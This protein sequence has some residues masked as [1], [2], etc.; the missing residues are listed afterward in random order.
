MCGVSRR[1]GRSVEAV[2]EEVHVRKSMIIGLS[3]LSAGIVT[4]FASM[5]PVR[6]SIGRLRQR[7]QRSR[8][9]SAAGPQSV[10]TSSAR[11]HEQRVASSGLD[12][13]ASEPAAGA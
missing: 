5:E 2:A 12:Q 10:N 9:R 13:P 6:R 1:A 7:S 8:L 11:D 3:A 4:S